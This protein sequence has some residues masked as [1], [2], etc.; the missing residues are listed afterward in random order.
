MILEWHGTALGGWGRTL[1]SNLLH[2]WLCNQLLN[3]SEGN[4]GQ[5][6][7]ILRSQEASWWSCKHLTIRAGDS[8]VDQWAFSCGTPG[9]RHCCRSDDPSLHGNQRLRS[10]VGERRAQAVWPVAG[11]PAIQPA[12]PSHVAFFFKKRRGAMA[13]FSPGFCNISICPLCTHRS[14][15]ENE[16]DVNLYHCWAFKQQEQNQQKNLSRNP[17]FCLGFFLFLFLLT[18]SRGKNWSYL[19]SG[20]KFFEKPSFLLAIKR[21]RDGQRWCPTSKHLSGSSSPNPDLFQCCFVQCDF[22]FDSR[23]A[24]SF[25]CPLIH[26]PVLF[27]LA[28]IFGFFFSFPA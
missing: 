1:W 9:S 22:P 23:S 26:K 5:W 16:T 20:V 25:M 21:W 11:T 18:F 2:E 14:I 3:A 10:G 27:Y 15:P 4:R 24:V 28:C 6:W 13:I 19:K 8:K 17:N 7:F 12:F